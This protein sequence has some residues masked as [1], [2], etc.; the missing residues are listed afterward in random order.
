MLYEDLTMPDDVRDAL[1]DDINNLPLEPFKDILE[2]DSDFARG[3]RPDPKNLATF[4]KKLVERLLHPKRPLEA[5][6]SGPSVP[7]VST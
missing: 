1:V 7:T 5:A 4:R 6:K 3:F 2:H